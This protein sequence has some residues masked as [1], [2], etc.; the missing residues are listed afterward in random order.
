[1]ETPLQG[2]YRVPLPLFYTD[3][4]LLHR[5]LHY[6]LHYFAVSTL[7]TS[8]ISNAYKVSNSSSQAFARQGQAKSRTRAKQAT[9][10]V[11]HLHVKDK[12]NLARVQSKQQR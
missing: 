9:A 2:P 12:R 7:R 4:G 11:K 8:V 3:I 6:H 10:V 1:M 5:P